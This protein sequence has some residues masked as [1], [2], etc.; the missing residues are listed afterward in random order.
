MITKFSVPDLEHN[1]LVHKLDV[2]DPFLSLRHRDL[3][4]RTQKSMYT[5]NSNVRDSE[6][7]LQIQFFF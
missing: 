3:L 6:F 2:P 5:P 7:N 1:V 4:S